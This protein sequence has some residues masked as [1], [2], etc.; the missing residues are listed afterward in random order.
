MSCSPLVSTL[1][2]IVCLGLMAV[3]LLL[4]ATASRLSF[5]GVPVVGLAAFTLYRS[6]SSTNSSTSSHQKRFDLGISCIPKS[7][8]IPQFIGIK[9]APCDCGEDS[10][11]VAE[12][13]GKILLV[14]ADGVG[15]WR[16]RGINPA[17]FSRALCSYLKQ[18]FLMDDPN[19]S[20]VQRIKNAFNALIK[21]TLQADKSL[22][23]KPF[24]SSTVCAVVL[25]GNQA[26]VANIGDS[27]FILFRQGKVIFRTDIQQHRFNAPFQ[28][29]LGPD[30]HIRDATE[31]AQEEVLTLQ[32]GDVLLLASDGVL[33]NVTEKELGITVDRYASKGAQ[34]TAEML[35]TQAWK[36]S[37]QEEKDSPFA[38]EARKHGVEHIGGKPDDITVLVA[39]YEE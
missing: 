8:T 34:R 9:V 16:K 39:I 13:D 11:A 17:L 14:V 38:K 18:S 30:G 4:S 20:L 15:S 27:G 3:K 2:I 7:M 10:Y 25:E 28:L 37:Q 33:D 22:K 26:Q 23:E 1:S 29:L 31:K 35:A 6:S 12:K 24:G 36:Q 5:L 21:Q 19:I 32:S